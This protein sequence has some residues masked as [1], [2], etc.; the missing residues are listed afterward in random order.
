MKLLFVA[1]T[2]LMTGKRTFTV[3]P[4]AEMVVLSLFDI[5]K[6]TRK[7]KLK[8]AVKIL[9]P[10]IFLGGIILLVKPELFLAISRLKEAGQDTGMN[11]RKN[12]WE[13]AIY[14]WSEHK[15]TGI[16]MGTY[17]EFIS[18]N[19]PFTFK[20]FKIQ[21]A[22]A[23]HNI[24]YQMLAE[25]GIIGII[26][27]ISFFVCNII[28]SIKVIRNQ[29]IKKDERLLKYAYLSLMIQVWFLLYGCTGN[30]LYL[31]SQFYIYLFAI[32]INQSIK[33]EVKRK[34]ML[35]R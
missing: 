10:A 14:L 18:R 28:N 20:V 23:A 15:Y 33:R 11:G 17:Q 35:S 16:G 9:I 31:V 2:L 13:L 8:R 1:G 22:Y 30:P 19:M 25:I 24:Y 21:T 32:M 27:F 6:N 7:I 29:Y 3:I 26:L 4:V 12:F 5:G 34:R